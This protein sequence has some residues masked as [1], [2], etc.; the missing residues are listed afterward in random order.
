MAADLLCFSHLRWHF[1]FQRPHHLMSRCA[2]DRRVFFIEEPV[3]NAP[4]SR[5]EVVQEQPNLWRVVAHLTDDSDERYRS[6]LLAMC[7]ERKIERPIHW[8]YTPM[9]LPL[10]R[11]LPHALTVY[12][13]M[14]ELGN[15][16]GAP[17]NLSALSQQLLEEAA[18]VFAGGQALYELKRKQHRNV[19]LFPSSVDVEFFGRARQQLTEPADQASIPHPRLGYCGVI[20]ERLDLALI[21]HIARERPDWQVV[22]LGPTVKLDPSVLPRL[23]NIHYLGFKAYEDL[24]SYLASWDVAMLPFALNDATRYISPTKTPEYLAAARRVVSTAI[25]DVVEPYGRLGLVRIGHDPA[26]FVQQLTAAMEPGG[27]PDEAS[28]DAFLGRSSWDSTWHA[29]RVIIE[30]HLKPKHSSDRAPAPQST[31]GFHV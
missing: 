18:V 6:M 12:D 30:S 17:A 13:C 26:E 4:T 29:M 27:G 25:R 16:L 2:R 22:L 20:D 15:F 5:L 21:E 10:A 7:Q 11:G 3:V 19:H 23:P 31:E 28:R 9:L 14:D 24:P 1:V 8:F